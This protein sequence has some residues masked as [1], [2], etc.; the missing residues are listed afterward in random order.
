MYGKEFWKVDEDTCS[1]EP[2]QTAN[3]GSS[4][5]T[6]QIQQGSPGNKNKVVGVY[7]LNLTQEIQGRWI[8]VV[9][10]YCCF[11]ANKGTSTH[12]KNN[13]N[14]KSNNNKQQI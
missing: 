11:R 2:R 4:W 6:L 13:N 9:V 10:L 5:D 12:W 1:L 3:H 8:V 7:T 14:K